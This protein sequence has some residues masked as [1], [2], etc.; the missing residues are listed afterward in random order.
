MKLPDTL[1]K[2][3]QALSSPTIFI[4]LLRQH[5]GVSGIYDGGWGDGFMW[6][7]PSRLHLIAMV[8]L[9]P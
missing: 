8:L 7:R 6:M 9:T 5:V 3:S 1:L 2:L 4:L